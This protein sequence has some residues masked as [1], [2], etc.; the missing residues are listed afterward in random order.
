MRRPS[1]P[2]VTV[3]RCDEVTVA[4]IE[5]VIGDG[6]PGPDQAKAFTRCGMGPCQGRMCGTVVS[7]MFAERRHADVG[8]VGHYRIRPPVKPVTVGEL[9]GLEGTGS[10]PADRPSTPI[11]GLA[12]SSAP[13]VEHLLAIP[14][15]GDDT[16]FE[17][18][19]SGFRPLDL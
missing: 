17:R 5:R 16:D 14:D 6:C 19:S 4:E 15:A 3:C 10:G 7:E 18:D 2:A 13:F 1:D 8:A 12:K 9:A 11:S